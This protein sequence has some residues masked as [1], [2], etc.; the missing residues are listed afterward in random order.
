[1]STQ[2]QKKTPIVDFNEHPEAPG[3]PRLP[4]TI[5]TPEQVEWAVGVINKTPQSVQFMEALAILGR[6]GRAQ[7]MRDVA[8]GLAILSTIVLTQ[9]LNTLQQRMQWYSSKKVSADNTGH[10]ERLSKA[11]TEN[12]KAM[13]EHQKFLANA[14]GTLAA[15]PSGNDDPPPTNASFKPGQLVGQP[16]TTTVLERITTTVPP[17]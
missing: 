10:I 5:P 12:A 7:G 14:E 1:M 4:N 17:K 11:V 9:N 8:R 2:P 16:G 6:S 3:N 13:A 15:L